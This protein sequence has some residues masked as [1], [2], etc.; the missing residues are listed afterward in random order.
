MMFKRIDHLEITTGNL[1]ESVD[2]YTDVIGFKFKENMLVNHP[3][4]YEIVFLT[5]GDTMLE[6]LG[7]HQPDEQSQI[8]WQT[9]YHQMAIEVDNMEKALEYL[10]TKGVTISMDP[11]KTGT[12]SRAK[13]LDPNGLSIELRQW[14]T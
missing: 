6:L 4:L 11:V 9:G 2:F 5:L 12:S 13:I 1:K 14:G 7:V 8:I 3:P 10:K